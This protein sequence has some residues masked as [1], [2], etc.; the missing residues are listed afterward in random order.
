MGPVRGGDDHYG[1]INDHGVAMSERQV[2]SSWGLA[3]TERAIVEAKIRPIL[4][5]VAGTSWN[6]DHFSRSALG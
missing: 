2:A 1:R 6:V 3:L 4:I 5:K